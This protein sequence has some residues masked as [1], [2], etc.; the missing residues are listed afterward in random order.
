MM[1]MALRF[2]MSFTLI[3]ALLIYRSFFRSIFNGSW[4]VAPRS[5][6]GP[7]QLIPEIGYT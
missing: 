6:A 4:F 2:M 5:I 3:L 1:M 7:E